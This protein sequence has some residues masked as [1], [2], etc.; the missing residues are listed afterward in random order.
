M[1][2][3][4][5]AGTPVGIL[6][7]LEGEPVGWCSVAPG[8]RTLAWSARRASGASS[9]AGSGRSS[10]STW[11]AEFLKAAVEYAAKG[12]AEVVEG[13]PVEP[14]ID[15]Q[16]NWHPARSYHF[17]GYYS[18]YLKAGFQD[19]TPCGGKRKIVRYVISHDRQD[20]GG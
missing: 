6:G 4:V 14:R 16:G 13:Y 8:R 1:E 5:R 12:E 9:R 10:V 20:G 2:G 7:Y 18:S 3:I 11:T 19:V 17:M 15:A